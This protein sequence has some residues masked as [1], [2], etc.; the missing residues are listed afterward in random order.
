MRV[1]A[2]R[3]AR[4]TR[5]QREYHTRKGSES[6]H[7]IS[8]SYIRSGGR[9]IKAVA[10]RMSSVKTAKKYCRQKHQPRHRKV[11][12]SSQSS[13]GGLHSLIWPLSQAVPHGMARSC[14]PKDEAE[15][16]PEADE[17]R[18]WPKQNQQGSNAQQPEPAWQEDV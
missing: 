16:R 17:R 11:C 10:G 8:G 9:F 3:H 1:N 6:G 12:A 14:Q 13:T 7:N 5:L 15:Q 2:I 4:D 18:Y